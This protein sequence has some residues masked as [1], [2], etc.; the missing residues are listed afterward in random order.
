M[1]FTI[2]GEKKAF[3]HISFFHFGCPKIWYVELP[4]Q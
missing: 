1:E 3:Q 4:Q 2:D